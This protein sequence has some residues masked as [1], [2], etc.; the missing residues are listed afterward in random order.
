L[1]VAEGNDLAVYRQCAAHLNSP[2]ALNGRQDHHVQPY[3]E[4]RSRSHPD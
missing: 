2:L 4:P 1:A 3:D